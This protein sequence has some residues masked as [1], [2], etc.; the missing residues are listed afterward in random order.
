M[1]R[2]R[3]LFI[4]NEAYFF[5]SHRLPV[6]KAAQAEGWDVHV[7]APN[8]HVWAPEDFSTEQ[9]QHEG[10][11]YHEIPLSRRGTNPWQE[12]Q[13]FLSLLRLLCRVRPDIVHLLTIKPVLYGGVAAQL[14]RTPAVVAGVTGLGHA[15]A[16]VNLRQ[17]CFRWLIAKVYR[18]ATA[19]PNL[20]VI[21]QSE[22]DRTVL[23]RTGAVREERLRLIRGS[24]VDT[25]EFQPSAEPAG[26]PLVILPARLIWEKGIEEFV[27]AARRLREGGDVARFALVGNTNPTNP[28]AVPVSQLTQWDRDGVVEWWGRREDMPAVI[29][30]A[31][32]V[33]LPTKYGEGVPKVL[34]EAAASGRPIVASDIPGCRE[35]VSDGENG[36]LT[37]PGDSSALV[38]ALQRLVNRPHLRDQM[39]RRGRQMVLECFTVGFVARLTLAVYQEL[40]VGQAD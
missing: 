15:F 31:H 34:I 18:V 10:I 23:A 9:L 3:L 40:Q 20:R 35:I 39:G 14:C 36:I 38:D 16:A 12:I 4:V 33:C 7:A 8:D 22:G 17:R 27:D 13:T 1:R 28:R 2:R 30:S 6:A 25:D 21:V 37:P 19:H 24:G 29:A 32:I 11:T 26:A 5:V